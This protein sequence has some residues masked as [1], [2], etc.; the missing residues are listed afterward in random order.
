MSSN[1]N[2]QE[3]Q[4]SIQPHP[5]T[6]NDPSTDPALNG[7]ASL[8]GEPG[9]RILSSEESS[10]IGEPLSREELAKRSAELNKE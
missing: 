2:E 1:N 3:Q 6:T 8:K 4:F 9:P 7:G 5:A 10:K